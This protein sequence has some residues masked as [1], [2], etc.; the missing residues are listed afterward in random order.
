ML[1]VQAAPRPVSDRG[2]TAVAIAGGGPLG[3]IY[4][5][6]ALHA[7]DEAVEG[8]DF[9]DL[10]IYVGVSS[11][12]LIAASLANGISP[13][14]MGR[15]FI[16][17][18]APDLALQPEMF[19]QPA[20]GEFSQR[21]A[22]LPRILARSLLGTLRNPLGH[23]LAELITPLNAVVPTGVFRGDAIDEFLAKAFAMPGRSNDF[24]QLRRR[25]YVVAT[26]LNTGEA[27]RF[28]APGNDHVPVS[29]AVQASASLP[30][31]FP[32]TV[33]DGSVYVDG[34]L[35]RTM[36]ASL[37]LKDG[38]S[39][40]FCI[41]PLVPFDAKASATHQRVRHENLLEGG[42]P[43][44]LAQ[45]FRALIHSRMQVGMQQYRSN[46]PRADVLLFEPDRDDEE[47]FFANVFSY[48]DR[49]RLAEHAYQRTRRDLL[50]Q[51]D[52]LQVVLAR[53]GAAL[54]IEVLQDRG[55]QF[56]TAI[57]A[58]RA[59]ETR[60]EV[61]NRLHDALDEL[62]RYVK[63]RRLNRVVTRG[64]PGRGRAGA[65]AHRPADR[66]RAARIS[67][68]HRAP[69]GRQRRPASPAHSDS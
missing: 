43:M 47:M 34:A 68:R 14:E 24:R 10:S 65:R 23:R 36:H 11:G 39:L 28:G 31:L 45:T 56:Q 69:A 40:V 67:G 27:V 5:L 60:P 66:V 22:A 41:N 18:D 53:H 30:G 42:L 57:E 16:N 55:R 6:G 1:T 54:D 46:Y 52:E 20:F 2:K 17:S 12:A 49:R 4:E 29:R 26:N 38:A 8:V 25:L 35:R 7:L 48:A 62:A 44:V 63:Q 33:I 15:I 3:A 50:E 64:S 59:R 51:A 13:E 32:P 58:L 9:I 21:L 37:A 19:L 61:I